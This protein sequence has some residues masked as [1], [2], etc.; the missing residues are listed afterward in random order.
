MVVA[1]IDWRPTEVNL[2]LDKWHNANFAAPPPFARPDSAEEFQ[3]LLLEHVTQNI[4]GTSVMGL[5]S[6]DC[7]ALS[8]GRLTVVMCELQTKQWVRTILDAKPIGWNKAIGVMKVAYNGK[9]ERV[10]FSDNRMFE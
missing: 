5:T 2:F 9:T 7:N 10:G 4:S 1:F 8:F 3:R 6:V